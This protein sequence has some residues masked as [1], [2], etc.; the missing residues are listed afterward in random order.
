MADLAIELYLD[1]QKVV[2]VGNTPRDVYGCSRRIL[3]EGYTIQC[4]V[5][6]GY[7]QVLQ[8]PFAS[9]PDDP[10]WSVMLV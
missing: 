5:I 3:D 10:C 9:V 2:K 1:V 7:T 6:H 8:P 4:P